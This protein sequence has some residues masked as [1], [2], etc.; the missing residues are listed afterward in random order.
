MPLPIG[1]L[2]VTAWSTMNVGA[3][4]IFVA[5]EDGVAFTSQGAATLRSPSAKKARAE[6][7]K[8]CFILIF[9]FLQWVN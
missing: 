8:Y 7:R 9:D 3:V 4:E 5:E 1:L 2:P 6:K